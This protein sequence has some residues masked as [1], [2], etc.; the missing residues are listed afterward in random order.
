MILS[1]ERWRNGSNE[2]WSLV[3]ELFPG[4]AKLAALLIYEIK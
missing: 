1:G 4:N 2:V 3:L